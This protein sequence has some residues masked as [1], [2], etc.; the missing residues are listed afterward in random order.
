MIHGNLKK[1]EII[2]LGAFIGAVLL[3]KAADELFSAHIHA[4]VYF[5]AFILCA[6]VLLF[7]RPLWLAFNIR[8]IKRESAR[9][10]A[11]ITAIE[12]VEA[13][14]GRY[15]MARIAFSC[16]EKQHE[17]ELHNLLTFR[18]PKVG[19]EFEVLYN[20]SRPDELLVAPFYVMSAMLWV[21]FG[22][23]AELPRVMLLVLS[24]GGGS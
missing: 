21:V 15:K 2:L 1:W 11:R 18:K 16:N 4:A 9:I 8:R 3:M 24:L 14:R 20:E 5:S 12:T 7:N 6:G 10:P 13:G 22:V 19:D 23:L 17:Y